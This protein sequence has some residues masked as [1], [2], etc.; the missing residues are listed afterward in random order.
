MAH[1]AIGTEI[2]MEMPTSF[3]KAFDK[4]CTITATLAPSTLRIPGV[5]LE[6]DEVVEEGRDDASDRLWDD[7][8]A[9]G[10]E[11]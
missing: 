5:L 7:D 8:E 3:K 4:S 9:E 2:R 11:M 10:L 6:A 1:Q